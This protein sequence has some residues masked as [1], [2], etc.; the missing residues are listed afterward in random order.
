MDNR[1]KEI[2]ENFD[3]MKI[4]IDEP[5]QFHCTMCG[6]CCINRDDI[7]L[8]PR[9]IYNMAKELNQTPEE[10]FAKYCET[11]LGQDSRFPLVRLLP[12]G[13]I[14]RCPLLKDHKCSVHKVKPTVCALF[15]I[16]R[17]I[18]IDKKRKDGSLTTDDISYLF[19]NPS[20]GDQSETHTVREWLNNFGIPL[21]DSY[22]LAWQELFINL[23]SMFRKAEKKIHPDL[24]EQLWRFTFVKLYLEYDMKMEFMPQFEEN[25]QALIRLMKEI[26]IKGKRK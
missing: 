26:P 16:G 12:R 18:M 2:V 20:C 21:N 11:Y 17:C 3:Q 23:S 13:S 14:Q 15:P 1:L 6:K 5:F 25:A 10:F 7:L 9:D 19:I 24:M 4:G 22:F 8:N